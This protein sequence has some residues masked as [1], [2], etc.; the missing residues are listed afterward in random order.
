MKSTWLNCKVEGRK[1]KTGDGLIAVQPI[2]LEEPIVVWG[3]IV[4]TRAELVTFPA[5]VS[6][7]CVQIE[8]DAFLLQP[9]LTPGDRVNHSCAPTCGFAGDRTLVTLRP[10]AVGEEITYD[11][12]MSDS[13][14]YD[15]FECLCGAPLCRKKI[16]GN[17]WKDPTLRSRY[18]GYMSSYID[19]LIR[20]ERKYF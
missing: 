8:A 15:E 17:D 12:A 6:A 9:E 20:Q 14:D 1:T 10:I 7:N 16:T 13:N 5:L 19:S 2:T 11:Y 18:A 3:G 4:C